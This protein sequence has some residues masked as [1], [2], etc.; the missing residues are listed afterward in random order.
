MRLGVT[1]AASL[2]ILLAVQ[3]PALAETDTL[4][5]AK[6]FGIGYLPLTLVEEQGLIEKH[7]K[8][9]GHELTTEWLRFSG[10]SG[11]F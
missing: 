8:A 3:G 11:M 6:Q 4:R 2:G 7:A 5:L 10:G 1:A 9:A